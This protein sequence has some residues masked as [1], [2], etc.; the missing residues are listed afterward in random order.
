MALNR[1]AEE[2]QEEVYAPAHTQSSALIASQHILREVYFDQAPDSKLYITTDFDLVAV[3]NRQLV[4]YGKL[5]KTSN[6]KF[7]FLLTDD[8]SVVIY[9]AHDGFL[10]NADG[11]K[12]GFLQEHRGS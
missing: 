9:V 6:R 8:K 11:D 7:P 1:A 4:Q 5:R 12:I 3:K 2:K 10:Y